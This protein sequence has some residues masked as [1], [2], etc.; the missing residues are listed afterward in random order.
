MGKFVTEKKLSFLHHT[1][2]SFN[3]RGGHGSTNHLPAY[4]VVV[5]QPDHGAT[6]LDFEVLRLQGMAS[7]EVLRGHD[8]F[9]QF[10]QARFFAF[11]ES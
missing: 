4:P 10:A 7:G 8:R 3:F 5:E 9:S 1:N 2:V 6:H 11:L